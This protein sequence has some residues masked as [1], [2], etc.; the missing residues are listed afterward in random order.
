MNEFHSPYLAMDNNWINKIDPTGGMTDDPPTEAGIEIGQ[1]HFDPDTGNTFEWDG[2]NWQSD[3]ASGFTLSEVVVS[4]QNTLSIKVDGRELNPDNYA[5]SNSAFPGNIA[6]LYTNLVS[7][8]GNDDF[9]FKITGGD[10][11]I[12]D[13]GKVYSS[14]NN[15]WIRKAGTRS[16]HIESNG[17]RAVDL[18]IKFNDGR[19]VPL[20]TVKQAL[21]GTDLILDPNALPKHYP[22]KHYHL[23]LPNIK[24]FGGKY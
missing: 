19:L 3:M 18:R 12:G 11:Y 23:Q 8:V 1:T 14:T 2:Q 9:Q 24:K 15:S 20:N 17:A 21:K 6:S 5:L 16:P 10:R 7:E 13:D 4:S 22:D